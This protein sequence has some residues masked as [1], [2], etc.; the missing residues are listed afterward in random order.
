MA[1]TRVKNR[2]YREETLTSTQ[3]NQLDT[4]ISN[5]YDIRTGQ[6]N[7]VNSTIELVDS[8]VIVSTGSNLTWS[9][10]RFDISDGNLT[11]DKLVSGYSN[12]LKFG[13]YTETVGT[14]PHTL[15][16]D[17]IISKHVKLIGTTSGNK[18]VILPQIAGYE[19]IIQNHTTLSS[20]SINANITLHTAY[21]YANN[22]PGIVL[23]I[24]RLN[25][26]GGNNVHV[27]CDGL[28]LI[29]ISRTSNNYITNIVD[30][31][32]FSAI[33]TTLY[34]TGS[35]SYVAL[36]AYSYAFY[37]I[38]EYDYFEVTYNANLSN[39]NAGGTTHIAVYTDTISTIARASERIWTGTSNMTVS[40]KGLVPVY[41]TT[42]TIGLCVK[43]TSYA[44]YV[45]VPLNLS[46][47]QIRN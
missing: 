32:D 1:F 47:K 8:N 12:P 7:D 25:N 11:T 27:Y 36:T 26:S 42:A 15:S 10:D 5:A 23:P 45:K 41:A 34:T 24:S 30:F 40:W 22:L 20:A 4:N 31:E 3:L 28:K 16:T 17:A 6:S 38:T 2:W 14:S 9:S 43:H 21:T 33:G 37:N 29:E 19:K 44:G 39:S 46:I 13:S 18:V 35:T